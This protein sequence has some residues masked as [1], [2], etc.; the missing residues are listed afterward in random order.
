[1]LLELM[2]QA[3][4]RNKRRKALIAQATN[5]KVNPNIFPK[6]LLILKRIV[7]RHKVQEEGKLAA[8]WEGNFKGQQNLKDEAYKLEMIIGKPIPQS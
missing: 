4:L 8:N 6:G 2:E 5:K 1:M 3:Y 7:G